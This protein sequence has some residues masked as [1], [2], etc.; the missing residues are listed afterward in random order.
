M[1]GSHTH[2]VA[3]EAPES[4]LASPPLDFERRLRPGASSGPASLLVPEGWWHYAAAL[5]PG[6]TLMCNFWDETN[7][8]GLYSCV[9]GG[10]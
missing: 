5:E 1:R 8:P 7:L 2:A 6:I 4:S 3:H 10:A 9:L